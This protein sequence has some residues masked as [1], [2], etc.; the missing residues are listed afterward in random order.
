MMSSISVKLLAVVIVIG[1]ATGVLGFSE[2]NR[3]QA[4]A[5][6]SANRAM[7]FTQHVST[8]KHNGYR[9]R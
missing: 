5:L 4:N 9:A 7:K 3:Q 1:H 2:I 6:N 8:V